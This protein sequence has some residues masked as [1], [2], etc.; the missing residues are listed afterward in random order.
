[1]THPG[2]VA[3]AHADLQNLLCGCSR[4]HELD[5]DVCHAEFLMLWQVENFSRY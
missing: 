3:G 2:G 5:P 1:M 4:G